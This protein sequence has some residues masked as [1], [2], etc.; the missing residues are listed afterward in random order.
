MECDAHNNEKDCKASSCNWKTGNERNEP[1]PECFGSYYQRDNHLGNGFK[2]AAT[3]YVWKIPSRVKGK[4]VVR[5]RYNITTH[6]F[7]R[8][9]N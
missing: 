9:K 7:Y 6:D 2:A 5:L 1:P 3:S 4:C 8:N